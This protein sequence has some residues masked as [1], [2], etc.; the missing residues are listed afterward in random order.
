MVRFRISVILLSWE[1]AKE[2]KSYCRD[3]ADERR[4]KNRLNSN[5]ATFLLSP[6]DM[7]ESKWGLLLLIRTSHSFSRFRRESFYQI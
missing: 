6:G 3:I 2:K 1:S 5:E 4:V 7:R